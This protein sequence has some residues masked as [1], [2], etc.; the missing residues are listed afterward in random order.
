MLGKICIKPGVTASA[1]MTG[2]KPTG[3]ST[4]T[5]AMRSLFGARRRSGLLQL[6]AAC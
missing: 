5:R 6:G 4:A 3:Q 2:T 1:Q